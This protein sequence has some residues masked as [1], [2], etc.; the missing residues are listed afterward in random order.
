LSRFDRGA[1]AKAGEARTRASSPTRRTAHIRRLVAGRNHRSVALLLALAL[2][3]LS[4]VGVAIADV[5][6][7][8]TDK[9]IEAGPVSTATGG[10]PTW[11]RDSGFQDGDTFR[12]SIDLEP[13]L[14]DKD[15]MCLPAPAPDPAQDMSVATGNWP[16]EFFY[17]NNT[18]AGLV[19][20][21]NNPVLFE[22][23]LEGAWSAEVV[24]DGDQVV[25]GRIRIRVENL[26]AGEK[27][28]VVHPQGEDTF[29]AEAAKRG[30]NYTQDIAASPGNFS[31][32][33][34]SRVGP[35]LRWAPNAADPTD[36]PPAGYIGDPGTDHKVIGSP[37]DT[38]Y[39]MITGPQVGAPANSPAG[40]NPNPC[41]AGLYDGAEEDCIYTEVFNLMGKESKT[42]GVETNR[43]TYSRGDD[44]ATTFDVFARSK[45]S[46]AM[47]VQD[48][49]A[50]GAT[51]FDTTPLVGRQ[52]K[53]FAHVGTVD[54]ALPASVTVVNTSD[55][56]DSTQEVPLKDLVTV[57]SAVYDTAAKTLKVTAQSS[58]KLKDGNGQPVAKLT[59]PDFGNAP[60]DPA[61]GVAT[62]TDVPVAPATVKVASSQGDIGVGSVVATGPASPALSATATGP[63]TAEQG[64]KV[65]L[66][67][68]DSLG[69]IDTFAW[70]APASVTLTGADTATPSFVVPRLTDGAEPNLTFTLTVTGPA[71]TQTATVT[72]KVL[73]IAAPKAAIV[74][75][76]AVELGTQVTLDGSRSAG[77]ATYRWEQVPNDPSLEHGPV[78][79]PT[80]KF[81]MP[82]ELPLDANG[83]PLPLTFRLTVTNLDGE[84]D[85]AEISVTG[86]SEDQLTTTRVRFVEDKA[87]WT[88]D[89]TARLLDSNEVTVH[90]G[91]TLDGKVIGTATVVNVGP[92]AGLGAFTVDV[93]GSG[94]TLSDALCNR[95]GKAYCVSLESSRGGSLLEVVID[96][97]DRLTQPDQ[98][99]PAP[100][101][102]APAAQAP[103]G[104]AAV[105]TQGLAA[106]RALPVVGALAQF[107]V[108][109]V[110]APTTVTAAAVTTTGIPVTFTA[111]AGAT[112][113]RLRLLTTAGTP[114]LSTFQKVKGGKRV[115]VK[116]RSAKLRG[117]VRA[118]KRYV[119]EVRAGKTKARLGKATRRTIRIR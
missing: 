108:A 12:D 47:V 100:A 85:V 88:I 109:R 17:Y 7:G 62:A 37:F 20:N 50:T 89:G 96:R 72:V 22:S 76:G 2:V 58:D 56:P 64:S 1:H 19:S 106:T 13:C 32:A 74:P 69:K 114:L 10:Y 26:Q 103:A 110:T 14:G 28:T 117:K 41:P 118:G 66:S 55:T 43:A 65:T 51:R 93:S 73:P 16:D 70:T 112:I 33:F 111:P 29:V 46:Q 82:Q 5:V 8:T 67:A 97:A 30:I 86:V 68:L 78:D 84:T 119:I 42:G 39:V 44:G 75:I 15:P 95:V 27:Y 63:A 4:A 80:L 21:G 113:A 18:A 90:A 3:V 116:I 40:T 99:P 92:A 24:N 45:G 23:A 54:K 49:A 71:G 87:R 60:V 83:D 101:A 77:A 94:V 25:F 52:G 9:L 38:N 79:E 81:T 6:K 91:P 48:G 61:T 31:S 57:P 59:L 35:F 11:Y 98:L 104:G 34:K 36:R 105:T 115:K 107:T 102:A 53:Y